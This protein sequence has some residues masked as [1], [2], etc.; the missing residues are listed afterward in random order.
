LDQES[1][2][3]LQDY[4]L[5]KRLRGRKEAIPMGSR[6]ELADKKDGPGEVFKF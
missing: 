6:G 4:L 2:R 5:K 3:R 1:L